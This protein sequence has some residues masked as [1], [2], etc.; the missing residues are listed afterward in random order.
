VTTAQSLS[1]VV[2]ITG[3]SGT[4]TGTVT[5]SGGSYNSGAQTLAASGSCTAASC[6]LTVPAGSLA[7]GADTLTVTYSGDSTYARKS[8]SSTIVQVNGLSATVN[9]NL[10]SS[11]INSNQQLTVSGTVT[12]TDGTPTGT[13]TLTGGGYTSA[14]QSLSGSGGYSF[15]IPYNSLSGGSD[16]LS[17]TYSG[18]TVYVLSVGTNTVAVTYVAA[19]TPTVTVTPAS[20]TIYSAQSLNVTVA[21]TGS[22]PAPTGTVILSGGGYTSATETIGTSPCTSASNCVFTIPANSL[23]STTD[24]L[25]ATYSGDPNYYGGHGSNTVTVNLSSYSLA[26][27]TPASIAPG[28]STTSTITVSSSTMYSGT[29]TLTCLL[30]GWPAGATYAPSCSSGSPVTMTAGVASGPGTIN[31]NTTAPTAALAYPKLPGKGRGSE[32]FGAGSG[33][34]LAFLLFLGI[35]ARRRSWRSMLVVLIMMAALG[36]LAACGGGSSTSSSGYPGT[37]AG[38]YTFTVTGTGNPTVTP[39]PTTTFTVT[40]T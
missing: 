5:L 37:S 22:G 3:A 38:T 26:A 18:N 19:L 16:I 25:T 13:V 15:T 28:V 34:V 36:S 20:S 29:V 27:T 31:V 7:I 14:A 9:V 33:V 6:T 12:G 8:N 40:V 30:T 11:A 23:N 2:S 1:V 10:S 24:T 32:L 35:P 39:A 4:P 21:V 17:V